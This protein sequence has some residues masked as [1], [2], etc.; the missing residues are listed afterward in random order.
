MA[1]RCVRGYG[2]NVFPQEIDQAP[3]LSLRVMD[4][5][6]VGIADQY[7]GETVKAFVALKEKEPAS[8]EEI[9]SFCKERLPAY[10]A[11]KSMEFGKE[12]PRSAVGKILRKALGEEETAK[13]KVEKT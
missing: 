4:A 1:A 7:R 11:P 3:Y 10:K 8:E 13:K 12:L 6:P 9:I 2:R 5:T